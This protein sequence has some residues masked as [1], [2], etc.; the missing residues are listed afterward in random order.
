MREHRKSG[1]PIY[2]RRHM[3]GLALAVGLPLTLVQLYKTY[4]GPLS[5]GAQLAAG[6]LLSVATGL[7]LYL[8]SRSSAQNQP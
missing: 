8:T 4:V 7:V 6:I 3:V 5:F 1:E 2:Q